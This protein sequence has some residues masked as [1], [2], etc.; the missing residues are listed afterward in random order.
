MSLFSNSNIEHAR[1]VIWRVDGTG[2]SVMIVNKGKHLAYYDYQPISFFAADERH[3][4]EQLLYHTRVNMSRMI[5]ELMRVLQTPPTQVT[6]LLGEPWS[7]NIRRHIT[8]KRKT[9]FK[10]SELFVQDL[11]ARDMKRLAKEYGDATLINPIHHELLVAGHVVADPWGRTVNDIR[12]DYLTGYSD[13]EATALVKEVI[14]EQMKV[15]LLNIHIDHYQ[16]TLIKFWKQLNAP[17]GLF[18][19]PSGSVTDLAIFT[20][21]QLVQAG[22]LPIG[23]LRASERAAEHMG[24]YPNELMSILSL[25]NKNLLDDAT[26]D[27]LER[28]LYDEYHA[29][30]V[31]FQK[32]CHHAVEQGDVIE[33][34]IWL[35][36][37]QNPVLQFFMKNMQE[38]K[39]QS[40]I[41]FGSPQVGFLHSD[42]IIENL[43]PR[44]HHL[45]VQNQDRIILAGISL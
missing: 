34:V 18:I 12:F 31:D 33:Q 6:V 7:H 2:I 23:L 27:K 35:G 5:P 24:V 38:N 9:T 32:F 15:K 25:Y 21:R 19:D 30:E 43:L 4:F 26:I 13:P 37:S 44:I 36:D 28:C 40:P 14:H 16:N 42:A 45:N 17:D 1:E 3:R 29:W 22:T 20:N 8:Y 41:I 10:L 11:I 39:L